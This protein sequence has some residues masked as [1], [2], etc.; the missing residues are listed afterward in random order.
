MRATDNGHI[1]NT[2]TTSIISRTHRGHN[3]V[4]N[5]VIYQYRSRATRSSSLHRHTPSRV[6]FRNPRRRRRRRKRGGCSG[7]DQFY[8]FLWD[9]AYV[10]WLVLCICVVYYGSRSNGLIPLYE[11][12]RENE[13][14]A[15]Y[16]QEN[17]VHDTVEIQCVYME[18]S[19]LVSCFFASPTL[20]A[21]F[22][23]SS[24]LTNSLSSRMANIPASVTT[25]RRSA[26]LNPSE[27]LTIA[28]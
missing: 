12:G 3:H 24:W 5:P 13:E 22:V 19:I 15:S 21:A 7:S 27:S 4:S 11:P 17:C 10:L 20:R 23:R 8:G 18:Y 28:S 25:L 6:R 1:R 26:P 14:C 2:S 16:Y 9:S